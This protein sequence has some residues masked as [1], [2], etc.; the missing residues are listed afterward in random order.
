[1]QHTTNKMIYDLVQYVHLLD[2]P[3]AALYIPQKPC[4]YVWSDFCQPPLLAARSP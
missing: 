2:I 1:M 3:H 4:K